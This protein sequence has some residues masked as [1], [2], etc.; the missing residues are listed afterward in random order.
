MRYF[1]AML[2]AV[3]PAAAEPVTFNGQIAPI[4]YNHCSSC[5]RPGEAA[6]FSLLSYQDVRSKAK[7]IAAATSSRL[8]PPWKP[9]QASY[10]YR[11]SR[12]LTDGD[13]ALIGEWVKAGMPEGSAASKPTPPKFTSGWML[14]EPDLVVEM[15]AAYHV[16]ADGSDI[17]RN[18]ALPLG[19]AEDKWVTAIDMRP[20]AR[21]VVHH[22]LYFADPNGKV[23]ERPQEGP[24]PGFSGM[25]AGGATEPLGGWA[26]GAQPHFYPEG[27]ALFVKKGSD[28]V[29]Q[30]HFHPTGKPEVEKSLIGF[31]FANKAPERTLVPIQ[32]P[33]VYSLFSG[34]DI[35]AGEKDFVIRDSYTLPADVDAVG[36]SA[37]AHY[38]GKQLKLTATLPSGDVKTMLWIKDWDFAWQDR[39]FFQQLAPLPK[40]TRLEAE[41]HWDNS[42]ENPRNPSSPPVRVTWGEQSKDEMGSVTL[43]A[44]PHQQADLETLRGDYLRHRTQMA[45]ERM[46]ADPALALKVRT[47]LAE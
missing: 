31:Y 26:V 46:M 22:V 19:L 14:G 38:I 8:M 11:D 16:P 32:L 25:R 21:A 29:I 17:Y 18:I 39:Y 24:E 41:I 2:F 10:P 35:P 42:A 47:L 12:R 6:P 44:V 7:I 9:E 13:I 23:H 27:L 34:L 20:S 28:L 5:H 30:Y 15:P 3:S 4:I 36:V 40:G 37:H 33:P 43:I 1:L 45:R